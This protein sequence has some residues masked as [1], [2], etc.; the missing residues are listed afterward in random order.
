MSKKVN[1]SIIG[2][3]ENMSYMEVE[4]SKI[5][6]FG[7]DGGKDLSK[8]LDVPFLGELPLLE[9][10]TVSSEGSNLFAFKENPEFQNILNIAN[11]ILK[12]QPKKKPIDLKIN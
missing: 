2:V 4:G 10:I 12:F 6:P 7:K 8:K 1:A 9:D 11:E 3:I 5:Y